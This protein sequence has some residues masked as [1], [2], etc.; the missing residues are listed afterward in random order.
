MVLGTML[1]DAM[2]WL[3]D[4]WEVS[5]PPS[6]HCGPSPSPHHSQSN[7]TSVEAYE[8]DPEDDEE[9]EEEEQVRGGGGGVAT[10][11][12]TTC[13][14]LC[15]CCVAFAQTT[16]CCNTFNNN[17]DITQCGLS[18]SATC[19]GCVYRNNALLAWKS[20]H[21]YLYLYMCVVTYTMQHVQTV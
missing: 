21:L 19:T 1:I 9:Y 8:G 17:C 14:R 16:L 20:L 10:A 15:M 6:S 18:P 12:A 3:K 2:L 13:V 7:D 11:V 4:C 5:V